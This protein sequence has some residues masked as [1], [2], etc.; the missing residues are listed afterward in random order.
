MNPKIQKE[1]TRLRNLKQNKGKEDQELQKL[2]ADAQINVAKRQLKIDDRF[3]D[4]KEKKT[5][6]SLFEHYISNYEFEKYTDLCT[7]QTLIY[8]ETLLLRIQ[9][10][11]NKIFEKNSDT[12]L[13]PRERNTLTDTE[14]RI[15]EL[16]IKLGIDKID[17]ETNE[18]SAHQLLEERFEKHIN[19]NKHEFTIACGHCNNMLLLRKRVKDFNCIEH[20]WFAGRWFFNY[21]IILDV[22]QAKISKE[23]AWRYMCSAAKGET[24]LPAFSREYCEDYIDYCLEN[25]DEIIENLK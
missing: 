13:D 20:P 18:L 3:L 24:E 19:A 22:K 5:A 2:F 25:W 14:K 21:Q 23:Q 16:K 1:F 11:I 4:I 9:R 15:D 17:V 8:E 12:Y 10:H 6:V 7:L